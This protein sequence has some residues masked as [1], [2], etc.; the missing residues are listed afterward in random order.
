[1]HTYNISSFIRLMQAGFTKNHSQ[2]DAGALLLA[3]VEVEGDISIDARMISNLVNQKSDVHEDIKKASADPDVIHKVI[4]Y[5]SSAVLDDL[6]PHMELDTYQK[7][8]DLLDKDLSVP[9]EKEKALLAIYDEGETA[10]FL[11]MCFL[12]AINRENKKIDL[13]MAVEDAFLV[14]EVRNK[15]P[16]CYDLLVKS[17]KGRALQRYS[18]TKIYPDHLSD[19]DKKFFQNECPPVRKLNSYDNKIALCRD[20]SDDYSFGVEF[21]DYVELSNIKQQYAK[22][23]RMEQELDHMML[24]DEIQDVIHALG[25]IAS[26]EKLQT[27][28][29][30]ALEIKKKISPENVILLDDLTDKVL[31]YYRF[32]ED[33]F[34]RIG[35][36]KLIASEVQATFY[37]IEKMYVSQADIVNQLTDWM[38]KQAKLSGENR[39]ACE[40]IVAF[41]VQNCEVFYEI[42]G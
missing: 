30:E 6:S 4:D 1:M 16:L 39:R 15:C 36:F 27:L 21:A 11:A 2:T 29:M 42:T 37:K 41:F 18:I 24:E 22:N 19:E 38:L 12:Y 17:T 8:I 35:N 31:K 10:E 23:Y 13:D 9:P 33:T 7:M 3:S 26:I 14:N 5:F 28:S 32:I 25:K 20:C 40:I 34:S